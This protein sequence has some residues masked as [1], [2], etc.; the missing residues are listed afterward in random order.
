MR[1]GAHN[2]VNNFSDAGRRKAAGQAKDAARKRLEAFAEV[3][4]SH[5]EAYLSVAAAANVAGIPYKTAEK[6]FA[7]IRKELG[8]QAV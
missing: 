2:W 3:L 8:P 4:A 1:R 6:Y 7:Q 5:D